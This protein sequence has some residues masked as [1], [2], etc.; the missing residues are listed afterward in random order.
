MGACATKPKVDSGK[1]PAPVPEKNVEEKDV[2]V[3]T[4]ASVEAEKTFEENQRDKGKEVVDDDK[5]DDQSVKRRS[6]SR[7]FKEVLR[8]NRLFVSS[9]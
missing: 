6:L 3:D 7:L 5:V 1:A 4:V 8:Y 2:F 9:T